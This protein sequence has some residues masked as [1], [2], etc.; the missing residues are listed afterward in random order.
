M[1]PGL[2][3]NVEEGFKKKILVTNKIKAKKSLIIYKLTNDTYMDITT[4]TAQWN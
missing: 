2:Q 3:Y 1:W 4:K